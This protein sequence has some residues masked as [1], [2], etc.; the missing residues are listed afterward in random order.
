MFCQRRH[1][2]VARINIECFLQCVINAPPGAGLL[3]DRPLA[4]VLA[5]GRMLASDDDAP[6]R[7]V[8][9]MSGGGSSEE[10]SPTDLALPCF[11]GGA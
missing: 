3:P 5:V 4:V 6:D 2:K 1:L 10:D 9:R 11:W 7:S 8:A